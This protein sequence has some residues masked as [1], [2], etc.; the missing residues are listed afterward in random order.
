MERAKILNI[1]SNECLN[2]EL[3]LII[4]EEMI[5]NLLLQKIN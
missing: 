3:M 4:D 1:Y 2:T 5:L